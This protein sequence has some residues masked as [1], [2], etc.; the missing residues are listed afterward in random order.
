MSKKALLYSFIT[1]LF[2]FS[3]NIESSDNNIINV[4]E[5]NEEEIFETQSGVVF[6]IRP[7]SFSKETSITVSEK[8]L[9]ELGNS[10]VPP[11]EDEFLKKTGLFY[12]LNSDHSNPFNRFIDVS[13]PFKDE[14]IPSGFKAEDIKIYYFNPAQGVWQRIGGE[15]VNTE[16]NSYSVTASFNHFSVFGLFADSYKHN[17][18]GVENIVVSPNPFAPAGNVDKE[19][20]TLKFE[21]KND[22]EVTLLVFDRTGLKIRELTYHQSMNAGINTVEWDGRDESENVVP[23]GIYVFHL[24]VRDENGRVDRKSGTI[25]VSNNLNE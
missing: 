18:G 2:I 19:V 11:D 23:T 6:N 16:N 4:S 25:I 24:T 5:V 13:F 17:T 15:V 20:V 1:F 9:S 7:N 10:V 3:L 12:K 8:T 14:D 22:S 21:L